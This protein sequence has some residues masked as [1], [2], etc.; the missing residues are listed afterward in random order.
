MREKQGKNNMSINEW[1]RNHSK[2][3][4]SGYFGLHPHFP[5]SHRRQDLM[6]DMY[7]TVDTSQPI[8]PRQPCVEDDGSAEVPMQ[9]V[10]KHRELAMEISP[11]QLVVEVETKTTRSQAS[12]GEGEEVDV[13]LHCAAS[14]GLIDVVISILAKGNTPC[15]LL[16]HCGRTA[17]HWAAEQGHLLVTQALLYAGAYVES[18]TPRKNTP[19]MLAAL[20][21]H[22]EVVSVL[23]EAGAGKFDYR[24]IPSEGTPWRRTALHCAAARGHFA[25]VS[26]L[27]N[28]GFDKEQRDGAGLTPAEISARA[29][30]TSSPRVTRCLLPRDMGGRMVHDYVNMVMEDIEIVA[31]LVKCGAY[32]DWQDQIGNSPLHRAA[33]FGHV[34]ISNI[35]LQSGAEVDLRNHRGGSP[36]HVAACK[37][38]MPIAAALLE[39]G[40]SIDGRMVNGRSPLHLAVINDNID[41]VRL[42]LQKGAFTEHRDRNRG[43]TPL[44]E[45][46]EYGLDPIIRVLI[47]A[48]ANVESTSSAGL[49]PLHWACRFNHQKS[50]EVLLAFGANPDAVDEA[51]VKAAQRMWA[52]GSEPRDTFQPTASDVVGLGDPCRCNMLMRRPFLGELAN[53][54]RQRSD[55]VSTS[56]IMSALQHAR[57]DRTWRRRGWLLI[58]AYRREAVSKGRYRMGLSRNIRTEESHVLDCGSISNDS[59]KFSRAIS[60]DGAPRL[61]NDWKVGG[62]FCKKARGAVKYSKRVD[63]PRKKRTDDINRSCAA[64][65]LGGQKSSGERQIEFPDSITSHVLRQGTIEALLV[66]ASVEFGIFRN[67]VR[68]I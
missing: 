40:A 19:L 48:G 24:N 52:E 68:F 59:I 44:S 60:C 2:H 33:H 23:L 1:F 22:E 56:H 65:R 36:L 26:R 17:L 11:R 66:L 9:C 25:V 50:V 64:S 53:V 12:S 13:M 14:Q 30:H 47:D 57:K 27:L 43:Q 6:E 55:T 20:H 35:L 38:S 16:D 8:V 28:V 41:V 32:L 5:T 4:F 34:T 10:I 58:L 46:A 37:G 45:A 3:L 62:I 49:T 63:S 61:S 54:A 21:G 7:E 29:T 31:G 67:V 39:A 42:L 15:D 51:A 18:Q